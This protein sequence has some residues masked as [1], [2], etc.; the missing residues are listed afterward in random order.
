LAIY[1]EG[2]VSYTEAWHLSPTEREILIKTLNRYN[3]AKSGEK[4][5]EWMD[6]DD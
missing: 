1:S 4:G 3:R 2:A 6:D 5:G